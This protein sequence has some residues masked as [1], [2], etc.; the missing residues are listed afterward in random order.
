MVLKKENVD[1]YW[2]CL[3]HSGFKRVHHCS[4]RGIVF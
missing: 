1:T 2:K 4:I 3:G